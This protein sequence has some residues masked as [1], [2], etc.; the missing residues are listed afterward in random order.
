MAVNS[1]FEQDVA[2]FLVAFNQV[3]EEIAKVVVGQKEIVEEILIGLFAGGHILLEGVPGIGKT[4]LVHTLADT[5]SCKFS[6]IQFTPDLMPT[7]IIGTRIVMED[8]AG[9]KHFTFQHGPIFTQI[10]LAD[11]INRAT[12]KTQSALLEAMQERSVTT[13]GETR[14]LERPFFVIATQNPL[15]MEGTYPLP[16]AQ[17]DRF[18][19]K[20]L[21]KFPSVDDLIEVSRRTTVRAMPSADVTLKDETV[22]QLMGTVRDMPIAEHVERYAANLLIATH[23]ESD[24]ATPMVKRYGK[25]GASPRGLQAMVLGGKVRALLDRRFNVAEDDIRAVAKPAL[26]HRILLNF[27]GEAEEISTDAIMDEIIEKV[28][29]NVS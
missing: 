18:F 11:E 19:F 29:V 1:Q 16:E 24:R 5:L 17:L 14:K 21:V 25:Y 2:Q 4:L 23:P 13:A 7:D 22:V 20:L 9:R 26:R 28:T 6:R 15:E 12:P 8:D 3:R 10:L 27:E